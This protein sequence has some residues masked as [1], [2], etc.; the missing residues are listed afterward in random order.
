MTK[1]CCTPTT[2]GS[3]GA[4]F[5]EAIQKI[6]PADAGQ[7]S[8]L[9]AALINIPGGFFDMGARKSRFPKDRDSPRRRVK[10][11]PFRIAPYAVTNRD[12]G[13]FVMATGYRTVAEVEGWSFV[14]QLFLQSPEQ[15]QS[16]PGLPW[17]RK[18]D[19]SFWAAPEGPASHVDDRPDHPV[20][21]ISW[22]DAQAYCRWS[23]LRLPSEAEW[24]RAARGG[25]ARAK[26]PWGNSF[27]PG[28]AHAM[29]TWQGHF[30]HEN[31]GEDG[32]IGTAPVDA[33]SANGFG[34]HNMTGNVWEW[35]ADLFDDTSALG[36]RVQRGGSFLCHDSYCDRYH[37]HSR[38]GTEPD[39]SA[40][41][42]GF[43]VA[44]DVE[45]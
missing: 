23:G 22:Y 18:V 43:R 45:A 41:H 7:Q 26:F 34:L 32:H 27:M 17:W 20:V 44:A 19:G 13:R 8:E 12:Y 6:I 9:R 16:P 28:G 38:T 39:S 31:T 29:N 11:A 14:F 33:F 2:D 25:I 3:D 37:V 10:V 4:P 24:E 15:F 42:S 5:V 21:H 40:G 36:A 30:P 1:A 35:A